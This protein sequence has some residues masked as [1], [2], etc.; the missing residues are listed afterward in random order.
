M[1][2]TL[3]GMTCQPLIALL[4]PTIHQFTAAQIMCQ[5]GGRP[6]PIRATGGRDLPVSGY[7]QR[8]TPCDAA[9]KRRRVSAK[10]LLVPSSECRRPRGGRHVAI[11]LEVHLPAIPCGFSYPRARPDARPR[12]NA[13]Q[14]VRQYGVEIGAMQVIIGNP[15]CST[16]TSPSG[17]DS[18]TSPVCQ[19]RISPRSG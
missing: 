4:Y 19:C 14:C 2:I 18:N 6:E 12:G 5:N 9:S 17:R 10:Q 3:A 16:P 15:Y 13:A 7:W 1:R 8:C 11:I